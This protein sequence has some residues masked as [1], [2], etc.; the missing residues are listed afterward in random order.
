MIDTQ[1]QYELTTFGYIKMLGSTIELLVNEL[2]RH[3]TSSQYKSTSVH[4]SRFENKLECMQ[5]S[6]RQFEN[7]DQ[8]KI[9][10]SKTLESLL[11][12]AKT[13]IIVLKKAQPFNLTVMSQECN[14]GMGSQVGDRKSSIPRN[15]KNQTPPDRKKLSQSFSESDKMTLRDLEQEVPVLTNHTRKEVKMQILKSRIPK[16]NSIKKPSKIPKPKVNSKSKIEKATK[17]RLPSSSNISFTPSKLDEG[18]SQFGELEKDNNSHP[19]SSTCAYSDYFAEE[20][21]FEDPE[22]DTL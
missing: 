15:L 5:K 7:G 1:Q 9:K 17:I 21:I 16:P 14:Q 20:I 18:Y 4:T 10:V 19:G 22:E 12:Q 8:I 6:L 13:K 11:S 3:K 2:M